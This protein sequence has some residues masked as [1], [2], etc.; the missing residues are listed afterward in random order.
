MFQ[1]PKTPK[2]D[3]LVERDRKVV[4]KA[5]HLSYFNFVVDKG[6]GSYLWDVDGN[7][8]I[9]FLTSASSLNTGVNHPKVKAAMQAQLDK[10]TQYTAAYTYNEPAISYAEKLVAQY[11]GKVPAKVCFGNCGSDANDAAIKFSRAYQSDKKGASCTK[12]I[13]FIDGYHGNTYGASSLSTCTTRMRDKMGPFLP[14]I[15]HFPFYPMAMNMEAPDNKPA[16]FYVKEIKQAFATYLPPDEVAAIIIEPIQGDAGL[17][18]A[19]PK[20]M[21]ELYALCQEHKILFIAEEV[22]QAFFRSG[23]MFSIEHYNIVPDGII[24]GK[25][26]GGGGVLGAF[27][28]KADIMNTLPAP[29]HL[30]TL[31]ANAFSCAAASAQLDVLL[32]KGTQDHMAK[33]AKVM[34]ECIEDLN[35]EYSAGGKRWLRTTG[36][37]MSLG[38]HLLVEGG[39]GWVPLSADDAFKIIYRCYERGLIVI[40]LAGNVLRLQ[41]ALTIEESVLRAGF[42]ILKQAIIDWKNG[43]I[44]D[45]VLAHK[46]GW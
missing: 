18:A 38:G 43:D 6:D 46:Q 30:F 11:P 40:T 45:S 16:G 3:A 42:G 10:F 17:Q 13:T 15:F 25:S 19:H 28:G 21:E 39:D 41:P 2:C 20:F 4:A 26:V 7:K 34:E 36:F 33:M 8:Y 44:P 22:Q 12:I 24:L 32:E 23:P 14:D 29:A 37:G 9:D 27:M 5:N 35:K 31:G 1:G